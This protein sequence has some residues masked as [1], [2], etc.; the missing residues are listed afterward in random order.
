M[1]RCQPLPR[2]YHLKRCLTHCRKH[3]VVDAQAYLLERMGAVDEVGRCRLPPGPPWVDRPWF[4]RLTLK[5]AQLLS[6]F[7]FNFNCAATM[8]RLRCT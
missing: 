4:H 7:A 8:R 3:N 5:Y 6:S 2:G 1:D